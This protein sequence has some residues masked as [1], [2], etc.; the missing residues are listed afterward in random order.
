MS[1]RLKTIV[2]VALIEG[3]LLLLLV[4]SSINYL[5][6]S[7]QDELRIR[8][9]SSVGQFAN[10]IRDAVLA[11]DLARLE[12]VARQALDS[13]DMVYVRIMDAGQTLVEV[14]EPTALAREFR[15]NTELSDVRDD[16]FNVGA[17]ITAAGFTYGRVEMGVSTERASA[18][19][20]EARQHL[21]SIA[22]IEM[23]LV[24]LF[25]Y[26]LG[27]YLTRGLG[28]LTRTAR[29]ISQGE[30]GSQ[31]KIRGRD[32]LA[33]AGHAFNT[34]SARLAESQQAMRRSMQESQALAEQL[35]R[36]LEERKRIQLESRRNAAIKAALVEANMDALVIIDVN[37]RITEFS[38]VAEKLFGYTREQ[39][40]GQRMSDLLIP[41]A[42]REHH[43][44]GMQHYRDTGHGPILGKHIEIDA[45]RASGEL[46][47]AE[48][49]VQAVNIDGE[50]L[51]A[52]FMRD[53]SDRKAAEGE[54][55][56]ARARAE[57][58]SEA[59]SRFLAHMS[60]EIRSPLNAVLGS[61][62][63]LL[64]D[65]LSR[66]QRL[67]AQTALTSGN[68]L[69]GL[70]N[71]ILD[72]SKI[73]AGQLQLDRQPFS[74]NALLA[75]IADHAA[76]RVRDGQIQTALAAAPD[77]G[78]HL[79]GDPVR[80][81]QILLNLFDNA[82]KF[83]EHGAV[84]LL[85]HKLQ[86]DA[87]SI[88]LRFTVQDTGI[89]IPAE[90]QDGLFDE[91]QQVDSSDSTHYGGSG[92]GLSICQGLCQAMGG[93]I[94]LESTPGK[95]SR[96]CVDLPFAKDWTA[97]A[98]PTPVPAPARQL[99]VLGLHPLIRQAIALGCQGQ[100]HRLTLADSMAF[101]NGHNG[102]GH[103]ALLVDGTLPAADLDS[104]P[105]RA[106]DCG[107]ARSILL[108][109]GDVALS[110]DRGRQDSYDELL[111]MPLLVNRLLDS[112]RP[113]QP[114]ARD[115]PA[116][117][118]AQSGQVPPKGS[119]GHLLLAEDSPANQLV[120]RA[121]LTRAG[122]RVD[123]VDNGVQAVEAHA[124]GSYDLILMDL[125]M[126]A[127]D[128]LEAT[129]AIRAGETNQHIPI[130]AMTANVSQQ[131]VERC[132]AAGMDDF[133]AKPV[134][135]SLLLATLG[136]YL[137][138]PLRARGTAPAADMSDGWRTAPIIDD[139]VIN[140]LIGA[141]SAERLPDTIELFITETERRIERIGEA[142]QRQ[143]RESIELEAHTIK[144]CAGT[145]GAARLQSWAQEMEAACKASDQDTM[146]H[147]AEQISS[148]YEQTRQGYRNKLDSVTRGQ[149]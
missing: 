100:G 79:T 96:F 148:L 59:K 47:P 8:A 136:R 81:R 77:I 91:F 93:A 70:I 7:S 122:Y 37:D 28:A 125:R 130:L 21:L 124:R 145:F 64:D 46:F 16:V 95:G 31:V 9:E 4:W 131:D 56:D 118:P 26:I 84:V 48:L 119:A 147:L 92:L 49:T 13:P 45:M 69:L 32:E 144:G 107:I 117:A 114:K 133:V 68:S 65:K 6:H 62:G 110:I 149:E 41:P 19:I 104:L 85:V 29:A 36:D 72:F 120:A 134:D 115:L 71:N 123:I 17:D 116:D 50:V 55:R 135:S 67:Y 63:L 22:V 138:R 1:F 66:E 108:G 121:I 27:S 10:L 106:R 80:V 105:A 40:V 141:F 76:L 24:A 18:L 54:L 44:R 112:L 57:A 23:F 143:S 86:E 25:S 74:L 126:P 38:A 78:D 3:C 128:G 97:A 140:T 43:H 60:H 132:L 137:N 139:N 90:A 102:T 15:Q 35:G 88:R 129:A 109:N 82:L 51:F 12:S 33:I 75:D 34:M 52:G 113:D 103:D 127:M 39:A 99:L 83:T 73:E 87:D 89:G 2:G 142:L 98:R 101:D 111:I 11:T 5:S 14:G 53:I 146:N 94:S 20:A 61:V 42:V 58:A 30:L